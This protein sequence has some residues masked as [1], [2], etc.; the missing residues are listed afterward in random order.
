MSAERKSLY[1]VPLLVMGGVIILTAMVPGAWLPR[2]LHHNF[3]KTLHTIVYGLLALSCLLALQQVVR[4]ITLTALLTIIFCF[5][6]GYG[7]EWCQHLVP[8][9][10]TDPLDLRADMIGVLLI[11]SGWWLVRQWQAW[12]RRRQ[13]L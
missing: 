2:W 8:R 7:V 9:R 6:F 10:R 11:S 1:F 3:D 12:R 5:I 4:P 13:Q